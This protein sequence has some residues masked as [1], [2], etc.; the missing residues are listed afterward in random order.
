MY[1]H[2]VSLIRQTSGFQHCRYANVAYRLSANIHTNQVKEG[3]A[4]PTIFCSLIPLLAIRL[5]QIFAHGTKFCWDHSSRIEVRVKQNFHRIWIVM[6]KLWAPGAHFTNVFEWVEWAETG[7]NF[8]LEN[9]VWLFLCYLLMLCDDLA[10]KQSCLYM[11]LHI[12]ID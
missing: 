7:R 11:A 4:S 8:F 2:T 6:K 9:G 1:V 12:L 3:P 5:Q 10:G